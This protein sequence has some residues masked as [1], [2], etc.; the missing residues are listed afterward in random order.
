MIRLEVYRIL[1]CDEPSKAGIATKYDDEMIAEI[2]SILSTLQ[3]S[4]NDLCAPDEAYDTHQRSELLTVEGIPILKTFE[5]H[6]RM[7]STKIAM[8]IQEKYWTTSKEDVILE[9]QT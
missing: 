9:G 6:T 4:P 2:M 1:E 3:L 5:Y 7:A 8:V